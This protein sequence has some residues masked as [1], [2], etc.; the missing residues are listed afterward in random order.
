VPS[1]RRSASSP[2]VEA[3]SWSPPAEIARLILLIA[4][5]L[6]GFFAG[7]VDLTASAY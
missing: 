3:R 6:G 7:T 5:G 4:S 1:E 2:T